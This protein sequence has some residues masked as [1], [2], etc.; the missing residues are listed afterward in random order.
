MRKPRVG[1]S[2]RISTN[3]HARVSEVDKKWVLLFW[4]RGK[5]VT[6][7]ETCRRVLLEDIIPADA[8]DQ[9]L[10]ILWRLQFF[11]DDARG[12]L[13]DANKSMPA[14]ADRQ[15]WTPYTA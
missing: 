6:I 4:R 2:V 1:D 12:A 15:P 10:K 14:A 7:R 8:D 5:R 3:L 13:T 9:K 11:L